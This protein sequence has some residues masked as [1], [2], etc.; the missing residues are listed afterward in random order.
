LQIEVEERE[1]WTA[2]G[3]SDK[4]AT[5]YPI[6]KKVVLIGGRKAKEYDV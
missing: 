4:G 6:L 5:G 1:E 2:D 3:R